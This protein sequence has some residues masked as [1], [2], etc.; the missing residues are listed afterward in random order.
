MDDI[1]IR[2]KLYVGVGNLEGC[3][4]ILQEMVDEYED[5]PWD[6]VFQK[7]YIH[8][9]LKKQ[10]A[11]AN[12]LKEEVYPTLDPISQIAVRQA[13]SYGKHLLR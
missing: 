1:V 8:A 12:W 2:A 7:M 4:L 11:V 10:V 3:K 13:F 5:V 6:Y 9:C